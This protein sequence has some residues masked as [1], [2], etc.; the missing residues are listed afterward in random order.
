MGCGADQN[1]LPRRTIELCQ[2]YGTRLAAG[3]DA[4]LAGPMRPVTSRLRTRLE[5][6]D[7]PYGEQPTAAQL[8][9]LVAK[10]G[11]TNYEKRWAERMLGELEAGKT[12]AKSHPYPVQVWKLGD[13]QLWIVLGSSDPGERGRRASHAP[14]ELYR[15][16]RASRQLVGAGRGIGS[17]EPGRPDGPRTRR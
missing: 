13:D 8:K 4:V 2:Q 16:V 10:S 15:R 3:V 17:R 6:V 12:F 9:E 14:G 11:P 1:P 7:L 5:I